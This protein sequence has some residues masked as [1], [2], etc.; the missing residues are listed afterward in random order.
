MKFPKYYLAAIT[1][2]II[3]GFFSFVLKP[4]QA[5]PSPDILFY[6]IFFCVVLMWLTNL[7]FRRKNIAES[8]ASFMLLE[9]KKRKNLLIITVI[10]SLLLCAN[11]FFFIFVMNHI[12]V[13]A[14]S[15]SYL[16]CPILT[17]VC[18]FLILKEQLSRLQWSA[19]GLSFI[20]CIM[21]SYN[22]FNDVFYS[23]IVAISYALYLVLQKKFEGIDKFLLL[24]VQL[25]ITSI[26][27]LPFYPVYSGPL[28]TE[29][30]FYSYIL[31]IAIFFT[32]TP[33]LLN[34]FALKGIS[35]STLGIMLYIN[36]LI[37]FFL[38][39]FYYGEEISAMQIAAYSLIVVSIAVFNIGSYLK[40]KA[41]SASV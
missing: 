8:R 6:R 2:F 27:L 37:G 39:A 21:L 38:A 25:L 3:W 9:P 4:L 23:F 12:S 16:L 1:A 36:P 17:T 5:Y 30:V 32:I 26:I 19:V 7:L 14:A 41:V 20:G 31:I 35:S 34:L 28:P 22:S 15:F 11:W 40:M 10:S 24:S 13:K 33:M 29:A 18:A